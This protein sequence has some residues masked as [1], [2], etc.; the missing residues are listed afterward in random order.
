[1]AAHEREL[2]GHELL[3]VWPVVDVKVI[4]AG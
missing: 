3:V 1:M 4:D 2:V